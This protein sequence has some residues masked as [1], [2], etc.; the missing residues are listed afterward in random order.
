MPIEKLNGTCTASNIRKSK[1]SEFA[2]NETGNNKIV[3][4][5]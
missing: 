1:T 4:Q 2:S 3:I 5:A